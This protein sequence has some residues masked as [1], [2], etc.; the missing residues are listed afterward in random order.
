[1]S[2]FFEK[3]KLVTKGKQIQMKLNFKKLKINL[4]FTRKKMGPVLI[5]IQ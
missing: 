4:Y 3:R 1:M 2:I 5:E